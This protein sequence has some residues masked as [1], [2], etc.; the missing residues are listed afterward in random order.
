MFKDTK[1]TI[2]VQITKKDGKLLLLIYDRKVEEKKITEEEAEE[3]GRKYLDKLGINN[4]EATYYLQVDNMITINY[5]ATQKGVVVY[6]DLI[7]VKI[8]MDNGD[9]CSV[10][11]KGYIFNHITRTD[12]VSTI[13]M[14][15]ARN[16]INKNIEI[17][18]SGIA[19]IPTD[20]NTEVL[21]YEFKGKIEGR[22]FL[23][24]VNAK[25]GEEQD[26][27]YIINTPGG[28]LTM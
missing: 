9:V 6:P 20:F 18:D 16:I 4:M 21:T 2:D 14:E 26:V 23:I 15:Q 24:Y 10:E 25:T 13:T 27:L 22:E 1:D 12:I 28:T 8:A 19:I 7:K 3:I 5:A 11:C 17:L